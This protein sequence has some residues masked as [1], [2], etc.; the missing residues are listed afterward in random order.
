MNEA[1]HVIHE[2]L[3][4]KICQS[5]KL[6]I[7]SHS[8]DNLKRKEAQK[9][10]KAKRSR[11]N[12]KKEKYMLHNKLKMGGQER[13]LVIPDADTVSNDGS[14]SSVGHPY[15]KGMDVFTEINPRKDSVVSP[16]DLNRPGPSR[17]AS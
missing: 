6:K 16:N 2:A 15:K 3:G 13:S 7:E 17:K 11:I 8:N 14:E 10:I 9:S 4:H 12:R 5:V 1:C